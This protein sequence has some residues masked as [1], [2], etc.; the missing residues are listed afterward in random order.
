MKTYFNLKNV[1]SVVIAFIFIQSMFF[2][3]AG[4]PETVYI[5][6]TLGNWVGLPWFGQ[7]GGYMVGC[8]ELI[9][10]I[11]LFTRWHGFGALMSLGIISGAIVFHL[12]TPLGIPM[13]TYGESLL[14]GSDAAIQALAASASDLKYNIIIGD[15]L[16]I[17]IEF[18]SGT[19]FIMACVVWL[20][21][22]V[23]TVRQLKDPQS[24]LRKVLNR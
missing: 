24:T 15:Q 13:P 18:D 22:F 9:A 6:T 10:S 20:S 1:L 14:V 12:F 4:A 5:F 21:A 19:L 11:L 16:Y 17:P 2:K 3:F 7:Y 23:L 8:A